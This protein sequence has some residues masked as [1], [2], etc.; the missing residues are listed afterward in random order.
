[1]FDIYKDFEELCHTLSACGIQTGDVVYVASDIT[2]L[3]YHVNKEY[4][5]ETKEDYDEY[6]NQFVNTLQNYI[7][8]EGTLLFPVY[9]WDF[10][11]GQPFSI[12]KSRG[13]VGAL[14]NWV[15]EN[16]SD[17]QRTQHPMYSFMVW[18]KD[19]KLLVGMENRDAW[20]EDSPFAYLEEKN[21]KTLMIDLPPSRCFSFLH[22]VERKLGAPWRYTKE[23][24]GL[25]TDALG[26]TTKRKYSMFVRD[27]DIE[28]EITETL[29]ILLNQAGLLQKK[30]WADTTLYC[31]ACKEAVPVLSDDLKNH[32]AK[33]CC[34]FVEYIPD[35]KSGPT[36]SD[37]LIN[38]ME[39]V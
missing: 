3:M 26:N 25:Y 38:E 9:T 24:F 12:K 1:M 4:N 23:F 31:V 37:Y 18:G 13:K 35:W 34:Q 6:L 11:R 2:K 15:M 28:F 7:G 14:N 27:L 20:S 5:I 19:A 22:Y 30:K 16:R 29:D 10:C 32:D 33:M 8:S 36:H 21:A 39:Y 17:F